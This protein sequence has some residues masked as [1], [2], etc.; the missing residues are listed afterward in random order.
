VNH[1]KRWSLAA[2]AAFAIGLAGHAN[3][4]ARPGGDSPGTL[5]TE[6]PL[7]SPEAGYA[8]SVHLPTDTPEAQHFQAV[9]QKL[10]ADHEA[11]VALASQGALSP[12]P[13]VRHLAQQLI[14]DSLRLDE[15]LQKIAFR[16]ERF[17]VVGPT[18]H[19]ERAATMTAV[20][21]VQAAVG[22]PSLEEVFLSRTAPL[23]EGMSKLAAENA[24]PARKESRIVLGSHL[25]REKNVFGADASAVKAVGRG[26]MANR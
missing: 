14:D 6:V 9:V 13:N 19:D 26:P 23:L 4:A 12:D 5:G 1:T 15:E 11:V 24:E 21:E 7:D 22:G 16:G 20:N 2:G 18:Y 8:Y 3:A 17:P 25:D 10:H